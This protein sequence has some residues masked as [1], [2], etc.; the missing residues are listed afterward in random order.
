LEIF[1]RFSEDGIMLLPSELPLGGF[2]G[3]TPGG[4]DGRRPPFEELYTA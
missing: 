4:V 2:E 1:W 3:K